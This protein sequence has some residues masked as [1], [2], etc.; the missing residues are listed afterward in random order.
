MRTLA[1]LTAALVLSICNSVSAQYA[2]LALSQNSATNI[3][4]PSGR[5]CEI[6]QFTRNGLNPGVLSVAGQTLLGSSTNSDPRGYII[7]GPAT[8]TISA[9][10]GTQVF[11]TYRL[12][13]NAPTGTP[14]PN[15]L[16]NISTRG[17]IG[18]QDNALIGGL[19]IQG[20]GSK[21]VIFRAIGPSLSGAGVPGALQD[22]SLTVHDSF[23]AVVGGNDNWRS[24]QA[25]EIL[26]TG[27]A[28]TDDRESAVVLTLS[29]VSYTA[30]VRGVNATEG[31]GLVEIFDLSSPQ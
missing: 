28:P 13:D 26:A 22:P 1:P 2:S 30:I 31:V 19:I 17:R 16:G 24:G 11:C 12:F 23:G 25:A 9:S 29:Q 21:R 20:Q 5:A 18:A 10:Q 6:V 7:A 27:L 15:R 3:D 8:A 4:I 14:S